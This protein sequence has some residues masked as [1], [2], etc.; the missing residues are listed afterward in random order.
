VITSDPHLLKEL[1][2]KQ[3]KKTGRGE[4]FKLIEPFFG[5]ESFFLKD[6]PEWENR[7]KFFHRLVS[8]THLKNVR[9]SDDRLLTFSFLFRSLLFVVRIIIILSPVCF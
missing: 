4:T 7:R 1:F 9:T 2:T 5:A 6:G 8:F 3:F